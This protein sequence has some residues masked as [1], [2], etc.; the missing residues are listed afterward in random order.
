MLAKGNTSELRLLT[1]ALAVL[2]DGIKRHRIIADS[3]GP[4]VLTP[5][6]RQAYIILASG[7]RARCWISLLGFGDI[8]VDACRRPTR[9]T[10]TGTAGSTRYRAAVDDQSRGEPAGE[11]LLRVTVHREPSAIVVVV[12]GEVDM[13]TVDRLREAVNEALDDAVGQAVIVD[14]TEVT[15]LGSH[16]LAALEQ[17]SSSAEQ[18]HEPLRL[19]V[20]DTRAVIR[21]IQLSGLEDVLALYYSVDDA[22]PR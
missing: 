6:V 2:V 5:A 22:L 1:G 21:P 15:Y 11:Q 12:Q 16:G 7:T 17:A 8:R 14:L 3:F 10:A 19:V 18:R 9:D 20:D 13:L 4:R